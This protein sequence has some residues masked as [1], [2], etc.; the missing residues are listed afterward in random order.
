MKRNHS[1]KVTAMVL[2]LLVPRMTGAA[3][4]DLEDLKGEPQ[5]GPTAMPAE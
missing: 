5:A 1:M 4:L 3:A 2:V